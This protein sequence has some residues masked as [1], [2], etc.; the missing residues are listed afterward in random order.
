MIGTTW[1][2]LEMAIVSSM[3]WGKFG[4][5]EYLPRWEEYALVKETPKGVWL[6]QPWHTHKFFVLKE[7]KKRR[8]YPT[9]AMALDSFLH[10][11]KRQISILRSRLKTAEESLQVAE[12]I[13]C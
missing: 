10:R 9:K 6:Q 5:T 2:R 8:A 4:Y 11:K 12:G 3:H 1:Y 13:D 7:A